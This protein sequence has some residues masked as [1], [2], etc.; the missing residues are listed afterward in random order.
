MLERE[1][2][3]REYRIEEEVRTQRREAERFASLTIA[4]SLVDFDFDGEF[5][6]SLPADVCVTSLS[7]A[8]KN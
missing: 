5:D 8:L 1:R 4:E 3:W 7:V 6:A 2:E